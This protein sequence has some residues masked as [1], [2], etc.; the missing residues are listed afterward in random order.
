MCSDDSYLLKSLT[1]VALVQTKYLSVLKQFDFSAVVRCRFLILRIQIWHPRKPC[2]GPAVFGFT[3]LRH[4]PT[5]HSFR[6]F[7]IKFL[8][9]C[10][11]MSMKLSWKESLRE[12]RLPYRFMTA[13]CWRSTSF[14]TARWEAFWKREYMVQNSFSSLLIV[15]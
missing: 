11:K 13:N 3:S 7:L 5:H 15:G 12:T 2:F 1:S 8:Q 9:A 14:S 10:G 4:N 6:S